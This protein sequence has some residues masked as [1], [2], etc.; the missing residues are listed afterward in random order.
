MGSLYT[1]SLTSKITSDLSPSYAFHRI[2]KGILLLPILFL[3][4]TLLPGNAFDIKE[5]T[6][7]HMIKSYGDDFP[8]QFPV[9]I[10]AAENGDIYILDAG[11]N[12]ILIFN[13]DLVPISV[14]H[15]SNGLKN[16][17]SIAVDNKGMIY[18]SEILHNE[19]RKGH[20]AILDP[21]GRKKKV[22]H[23]EGFPEAENFVAADIA[24]DEGGNLYLA[25][26]TSGPLIILSGDGRF[27]RAIQPVEHT[28]SGEESKADVARV[29]LKD[30]LIY[31]LSEWHGHVYLYTKGGE[32]TK[33]F[34]KKGGSPGKL[35][36]AQG[37]AVDPIEGKTYVMDYLRHTILLF[38]ASGTF[39]REYG[40]EGWD[41]GW[42][43]YPRDICLDKQGRLF[44]ADTF[45]KRIQVFQTR[46]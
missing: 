1:N 11:L 3:V 14:L 15:K 33:V 6:Y 35:S 32:K 37:L 23:F 40:G 24:I 45:N 18:I 20:I 7:L 42:F 10:C 17:V 26:G 25:G 12:K 19:K 2:F 44:V 41:P 31:L 27:I 22:L 9:D 21:L 36:R 16:P 39:V 8:V 13:K 46:D 5:I 43:S 4:F 29:A 34:G 38:D 30:D 28:E